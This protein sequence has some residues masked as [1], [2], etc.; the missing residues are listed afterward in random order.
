MADER[1]TQLLHKDNHKNISQPININSDISG[2][3]QIIRSDTDIKLRKN[4]TTHLL[5]LI[6]EGKDVDSEEI[7]EL[8]NS[9][10]DITVA[11]ELKRILNK[12]TM[13][14]MFMEDPTSK[15]D[16][17]LSSEE[18]SIILEE[19]RRLGNLYDKSLSEQ[20]AFER[21][22]KII[23]RVIDSGMGRIYKGIKHEDNKFVAIK[24]LLL[25]ELSEN[26]DREKLIA[27]F[28]R[29]GEILNRLDHPHI[30]KGY[31]YGNAD[32]EY[33]LVMEYIDGGTVENLI[34][35]KL[36]D[37]TE[38]KTI[39]LQLCEAVLYIHQNGV[40]H[41]DIKPANILISNKDNSIYIKLSD[42]G[43]SKDKRDSKLSKFSFQAGTDF[44]ASP[45]QL[46]DARYADERDDIFSM[47][48]T[49]YDML[50]GRVY[51]NNEPYIEIAR[52]NPLAQRELDMII[53]KCIAIKKEDRF[54]NVAELKE[55][56]RNI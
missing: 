41:R 51:K 7:Q 2:L 38:F 35:N 48:K 54:Q 19:I 37:L 27:R 49:F 4:A 20:G 5:K 44:Y 11:T 26:N 33:F 45:Q 42:F 13:R 43:L 28:K 15:Y 55:A 31:E 32:G 1:K 36:I 52:L 6:E 9:E 23:S 22:Y 53:K 10:K 24:I 21:K 50:T 46:Q 56:L 3:Y 29:E 47:G 16:R 25:E 8:F 30:V 18:E 39:S 17:K 12:L 40:I 14:Q 34:A